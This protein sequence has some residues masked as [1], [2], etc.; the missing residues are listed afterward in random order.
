MASAH[1]LDTWIDSEGRFVPEALQEP[2]RLYY[3]MANLEAGEDTG[4]DGLS[5][6]W[7]RS[8]GA[9]RASRIRVAQAPSPVALAIPDPL[10]VIEGRN[11][12]HCG[13]PT[14]SSPDGSVVA[15]LVTDELA[16][17]VLR[18]RAG[19]DELDQVG[20][21]EVG[22]SPAAWAE[23]VVQA[24]R[25][26]GR[27]SD[28]GVIE[29]GIAELRRGGLL[30]K[31]SAYV[32]RRSGVPA[33]PALPEQPTQLGKEGREVAAAFRVLR[34]LIDA[35]GPL[36]DLGESLRGMKVASYQNALKLLHQLAAEAA[37]VHDDMG[38]EDACPGCGSEP[39][40]GKT[41]GCEHPEGCG[42]TAPASVRAEV[43]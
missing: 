17:Q 5:I 28:E 30:E 14:V 27:G 29:E 13:Y 36:V 31:R 6:V 40:D 33:V 18:M 39:G 16:V 41:D 26:A 34:D 7:V 32:E 3:R 1:N 11:P 8:G 9:P 19:R 37:E 10:W 15:V 12:A 38:A 43:G 35:A 2:A 42:H 21:V 25:L 24:L 22:E 23:A 20:D 4:E